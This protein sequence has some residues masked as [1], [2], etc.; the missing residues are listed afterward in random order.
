MLG[1]LADHGVGWVKD[2]AQVI[3]HHLAHEDVGAH[4]V[5][6]VIAL[7]PAGHLGGGVLHTLIQWAGVATGKDV[8]GILTARPANALALDQLHGELHIKRNLN[9]GAHNLA[10]ALGGVAVT[11]VEER[12][13]SKDREVDGDALDKAVVIHIAAMFG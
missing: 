11:D 5:Q 9:A 7:Q 13:W 2:V 1:H 6:A 8:V 3:L 10:V 12:T 4:G